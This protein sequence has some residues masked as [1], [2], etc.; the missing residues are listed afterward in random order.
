MKTLRKSF[1][2]VTEI[3]AD[4][5]KLWKSQLI[6]TEVDGVF[7]H[8]VKAKNGFQ[9]VNDNDS[10]PLAVADSISSLMEE[11]PEPFYAVEMLAEYN[12]YQRERAKQ[13]AMWAEIATWEYTRDSLPD[14]RE[15]KIQYVNV[16]DWEF[17]FLYDYDGRNMCG[18]Y[19][20]VDCYRIDENGD[21][22]GGADNEYY[23]S[24]DSEDAAL[25]DIYDFLKIQEARQ[26]ERAEDIV[27]RAEIAAWIYPSVLTYDR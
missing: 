27:I 11:V 12:A 13:N 15:G 1:E 4:T 20:G 10:K 5:R 16:G 21:V 7:Y 14:G 18:F 9:L 3:W 2:D 23:L 24:V 25:I 19:E 22:V 6:F 17:R 26:K 8:V